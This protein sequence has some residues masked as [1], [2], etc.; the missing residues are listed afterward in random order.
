M[1]A[2]LSSIL[3]RFDPIAIEE[4]LKVPSVMDKVLVANRKAKMWDGLV[5]L[6]DEISREADN[7][8]QRL[9]GEKFAKAY[10]EQIQRLRQA[11]I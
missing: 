11:K 3:H 1:R 6:Y 5:E 7:D 4:K 2:A 8:F 10:E 9:F